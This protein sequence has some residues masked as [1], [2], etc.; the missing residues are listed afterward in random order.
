[1]A[2]DKPKSVLPPIFTTAQVWDLEPPDY[3]IEG[4][5]LSGDNQHK[6]GAQL[7]TIMAL[8]GP[9]NIGKTFLLLSWLLCLVTGTPWCGRRV[10]KTAVLLITD[11]GVR[12]IGTRERGWC[13][14]FRFKSAPE[15]PHCVGM[16]NLLDTDAVEAAGKEIAGWEIK[17]G[18]IAIDTFGSA[19]GTGDEVKD[20]P[21][22]MLNARYLSALTGACV[23]LNHHPNKAG[24][25]ERGGGQ[26][27]NK[28]DMLIEVQAVKDVNNFR[29]LTFWKTRDDKQPEPLMIELCD[30][31]VDTPW[32]IKTTLAV[33]GPRTV[34]DMP[35]EALG[36]LEEII[37]TVFQNFPDGAT[38]T[39]L[40]NLANI[41][42]AGDRKKAGACLDRSV[43][44]RALTNL[45]KTR[46]VLDDAPLD[47]ETGEALKP[48]PK[49][50]KFRFAKIQPATAD[51]GS[52]GGGMIGR[53]ELGPKGPQLLPTDNPPPAVSVGPFL[54]ISTDN[55]PEVEQSPARL[56]TDDLVATARGQLKPKGP[57]E[58][59][60]KLG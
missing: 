49:G 48:R 14:K 9:S 23:L 16:L 55:R 45:T 12:G 11:E 20:M 1:M 39:E 56:K 30:Q 52:V 47:P 8:Y 50:A 21:K 15:F 24:D 43:F 4:I 13:A 2:D 7:G 58:K 38:W 22:A 35:M 29:Q 25:V 51:G 54:P 33:D 46:A 40:Y 42:T 32:G 28:V 37:L 17:P 10:R 57:N 41:A 53:Y 31:T 60:A 6:D 59:P 18:L 36:Q 3:L 26:F 27:R 19:I 5:I 34:A 44:G